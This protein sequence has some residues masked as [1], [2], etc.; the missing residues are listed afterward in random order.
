[1]LTVLKTGK[2]INKQNVGLK[3]GIN[4]K[5]TTT[6]EKIVPDNPCPC[7][8]GTVFLLGEK[9]DLSLYYSYSKLVIIFFR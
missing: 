3:S 9:R 4:N 7:S 6:W 1:M 5:V 2:C 8:R